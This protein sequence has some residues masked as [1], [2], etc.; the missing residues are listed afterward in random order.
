METPGNRAPVN[1]LGVYTH[2]AAGKSLTATATPQADALVRM[3]YELDEK[4]TTE[5]K[6]QKELIAAGK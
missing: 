4:A 5:L 3:G 2:K 6:K 1:E